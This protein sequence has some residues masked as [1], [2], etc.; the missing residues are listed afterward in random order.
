MNDLTIKQSWDNA[1]ETHFI[2]ATEKKVGRIC[3]QVGRPHHYSKG[4]DGKCLRIPRI[5]IA[6][7][8]NLTLAG[9]HAKAARH[10][11]L[12]QQW[13]GELIGAPI[14]DG[15]GFVFVF[16]GDRAS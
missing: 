9:A 3:A 14:A 15:N 7:D 1:I 4:V 5:V 6:Y 11:C 2:P 10:L 16:A 8:S 13:T 12:V